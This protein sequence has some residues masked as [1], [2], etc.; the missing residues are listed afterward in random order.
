[1]DAVDDR[2]GGSAAE[3]VGGPNAITIAHN[4]LGTNP[5]PFRW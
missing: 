2:V 4:D 3:R 5:G 1:M